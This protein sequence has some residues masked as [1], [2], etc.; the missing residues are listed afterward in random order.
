MKFLLAL[1]FGLCSLVI[2]AQETA[3][4]E[5]SPTGNF[6]WSMFKG[7]VYPH[8]IAEMGSN[9]G[10]VTVSSLS[11]ES[12][13]N[14]RIAKVRISAMFNPLESWT[15]YP[16]LYHPDEALNHEKRHFDICEI[17]ARKIRQAVS[18]SHFNRGN[19]NQELENQFRKIVAEYRS[20]QSRYDRETKHSM[21]AEQQKKWNAMIDS[22]LKTLSYFSNPTVTITLN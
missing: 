13:V 11:Y 19:F 6:N 2:N 3:G 22:Q 4:I 5:Y 20:A 7:K 10:A 21:D 9:T 15:K 12:E 16:K 1:I 8:H 17:Y 18:Q 14:G